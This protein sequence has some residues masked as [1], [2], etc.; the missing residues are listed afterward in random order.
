M[1]L[2][3]RA[4]SIP[5]EAYRHQ[6]PEEHTRR[7][8]HLR[9]ENAVVCLGQ[10]HNRRVRGACDENDCE[11]ETNADAEICEAAHLGLPAVRLDVDL[12]DGREE[13]EEE[14]EAEGDIEREEEDD[15]LRGKKFQGADDAALEDGQRCEGCGV[16]V[17]S[18]D[19]AE[20]GAGELFA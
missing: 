20:L 19:V 14:A 10:P 11:E 16:G 8:S 2:V 18:E 4:P 3:V 15:G 12:R 7:Q 6:D 13:E 5:E 1:R 9:F 17:V